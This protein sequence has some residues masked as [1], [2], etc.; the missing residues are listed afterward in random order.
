MHYLQSLPTIA[1]VAIEWAPDRLAARCENRIEIFALLQK[2]HLLP[3]LF[4]PSIPR[5][6]DDGEWI[7]F[8]Y[9]EWQ[10]DW[11]MLGEDKRKRV[12]TFFISKN[13]PTPEGIAQR[14]N[15]TKGDDQPPPARQGNKGRQRFE[16]I[17][18][19][20]ISA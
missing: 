18:L 13:K 8:E 12:L 7:H 19:A 4:T 11:R 15:P 9:E 3:F 2:H 16:P 5:N 1:Y 10:T 14:V 20:Q 17:V 6:G